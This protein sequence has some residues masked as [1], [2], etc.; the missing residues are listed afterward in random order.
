MDDMLVRSF[1]AAIACLHLTGCE[2]FDGEVF[3]KYLPAHY[4]GAP[5]VFS[6]ASWVNCAMAVFDISDYDT[7]LAIERIKGF[8]DWAVLPMADQVHDTSI[9]YRVIG[10]Q[11]QCWVSDLIALTGITSSWDLGANFDGLFAY[12]GPILLIID[13]QSNYLYVMEG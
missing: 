3:R 1:F 7:S 13:P 2:K 6:N 12:R 5:V 10:S 9:V 8:S 11:D 4:L